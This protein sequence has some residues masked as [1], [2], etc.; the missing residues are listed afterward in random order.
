LATFVRNFVTKAQ[1]ANIL[2]RIRELEKSYPYLALFVGAAKADMYTLES[3]RGN[4][5]RF[6]NACPAPLKYTMMQATQVVDEHTFN[7]VNSNFSK[8][9]KGV[10]LMDGGAAA[11]LQKLESEVQRE[12][13]AWCNDGDDTYICIQVFVGGAEYY[14]HFSLDCSSFDLT[15]DEELRA[16]AIR[17]LAELVKAV[18][19]VS[20]SIFEY[21]HKSRLV[22]LL[23]T[24]T[25][26]MRDGGPSGLMMQS[27]LN[28]IIMNFFLQ[29]YFDRLKRVAFDGLVFRFDSVDSVREVL[30]VTCKVVGRSLGLVVKFAD[31]KIAPVSSLWDLLKLE[32]PM[33][34]V[35]Y[36]WK[37]EVDT[38]GQECLKLFQQLPR[39]CSNVLY[40]ARSW[41]PDDKVFQVDEALRMA[42][43]LVCLGMPF[44]KYEEYYDSL[45]SS[46]VGLLDSAETLVL[47][48]VRPTHNLLDS[49][50]PYLVGLLP[51]TLSEDSALAMVRS[52][53]TIVSEVDTRRRFCQLRVV[54][55]PEGV[56]VDTIPSAPKKHNPNLLNL[57]PDGF[58]VPRASV[59]PFSVGRFG[60][61]PAPPGLKKAALREH[62]VKISKQMQRNGR[63]ARAADAVE[64]DGGGVILDEDSG[65]G[66]EVDDSYY[67]SSSDDEDLTKFE[68]RMNEWEERRSELDSY[69][70]GSVASSE[71][72]IESGEAAVDSNLGV[73]VTQHKVL[74]HRK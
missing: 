71:G 54:D 43:W 37:V 17:R 8:S 51:S 29:A 31:Y 4:M 39:S 24:Y 68:A 47:S 41:T 3:M 70:S 36:E 5:L 42:G 40:P 30:E 19:L 73:V 2:D 52:L 9:S 10:R 45:V 46:V 27:G 53:R 61:P 11:I 35:G 50:S 20:G 38:E 57:L 6:Y 16:P 34:Y 13:Y 44:T 22:A 63:R 7:I 58:V 64:A 21:T 74:R 55:A 26:R 59:V 33:L 72:T 62:D 23:G 69:V 1:P 56:G 18:D 65:S 28:S 48:G 66:S 12:G 49:W 67:Y 32:P 14:L 15:Q 25:V 60:K